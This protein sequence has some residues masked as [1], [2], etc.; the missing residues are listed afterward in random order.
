MTTEDSGQVPF[1]VETVNE[2]L[3][4]ECPVQVKSQSVAGLEERLSEALK[5]NPLRREEIPRAY[6]GTG[7]AA[8]AD[9]DPN[10]SCWCFGCPVFSRYKLEDGEPVGY[11]CLDG[12]PD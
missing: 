6:C 5:I 7:K 4:L 10:Q 12:A 1:S 2:C 11:Y 9:L 3:C 8:F